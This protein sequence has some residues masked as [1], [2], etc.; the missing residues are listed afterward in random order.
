MVPGILTSRGK[1]DTFVSMK[2]IK[3]RDLVRKPSL[4]SHL[5]P[6]ESLVVE[7][8]R[9]PL[10]ISRPKVKQLTAE[11]IEAEIQRICKD[12]PEMDCQAV[13]DDLRT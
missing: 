5:K 11:E 6:G 13:L 9:T 7:D 2:S 1:D 3:K 4:V 8:G 12:A 10:V